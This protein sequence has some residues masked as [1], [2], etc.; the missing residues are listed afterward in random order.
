MGFRMSLKFKVVAVSIGS[1]VVVLLAAFWVARTE[2]YQLGSNAAVQQARA[3][4]ARL[5]G[6]SRYVAQLN[7]FEEKTKVVIEKYPDGNVPKHEKQELL[8]TVPIVAALK[9]GQVESEGE[10]FEF[11][12]S[13][14]IFC[15][16]HHAR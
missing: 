15:C 6:A 8:L 12:V 4:M 7:V 10:N 5:E 16:K 13:C 14:S 3:V 2:F 11:R 1:L 9:L